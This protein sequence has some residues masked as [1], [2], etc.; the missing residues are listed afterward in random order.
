[1]VRSKP[2]QIYSL[3][4]QKVH[5]Y[6]L[7]RG[8]NPDELLAN[9]GIRD[10]EL[11]KP[12]NLLHE[13]QVL[14]YYANV[15]RIADTP[16][17]GLEIGW[18]S[19]LPDMGIP[20]ISQLSSGT[21]REAIEFI[22][23]HSSLYNLLLPGEYEVVGDRWINRANAREKPE[24]LHIFLVERLLGMFQAHIEELISQDAKPTKVMLD[25]PAPSYLQKY[26]DIFRCPIYFNKDRTELHYP[27]A[28]LDM[29]IAT[30][31]PALHEVLGSMSGSLKQK[32]SAKRDIVNDVKLELRRRPGVF[33]GIEQVADSLAMSSRTLRR[34]LGQQEVQF[35]ELLDLT[36][37]EVAKD[38]LANT[39]LSIQQIAEYCGFQEPQNFSK[40]FKR[41]LGRS[42]SE[43]RET[44][45]Q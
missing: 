32:L 10:A 15:L 4:L 17:I 40:A 16:G 34:K 35:Q 12:W 25:Y 28:Y 20:G 18:T 8:F 21:V 44:H 41:W 39:N 36:R 2:T 9:T 1:M 43:Y 22:F 23:T 6:M 27:A 29:K 7:A 19:S 37:Q 31:D 33:P 3:T 26:E 14:D 30:H 42:P 24:H 11:L 45:R 5:N 13:N 38:Y